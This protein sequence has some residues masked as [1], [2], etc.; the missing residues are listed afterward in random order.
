M[1]TATTS[2]ARCAQTRAA[3]DEIT[4][5]CLVHWDAWNPNFLSRRA[6]SPASSTSSALWAEPLM[7]AQFRSLFESGITAIAMRGYGK[8]TFTFAEEQRNYLYSL[9]LGW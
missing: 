2:C 1:T 3:L 5:P 9:H 4:A 6:R 7:E 8:T